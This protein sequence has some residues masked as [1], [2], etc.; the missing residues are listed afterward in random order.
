MQN[1]FQF[2]FVHCLNKNVCSKCVIHPIMIKI[3]II[4]IIFLNP[5]FK[6]LFLIS[7]C[8]ESPV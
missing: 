5:Y 8:S 3:L 7:D 4:M 2:K 1:S 6:I